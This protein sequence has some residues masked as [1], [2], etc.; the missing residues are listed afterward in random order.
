MASRCCSNCNRWLSKDCYSKTQWT[1]GAGISR[2]RGCLN[3]G[4]TLDPTR[5]ARQNNS[6]KAAFTSEALTYPFAQG[7]FRWV[8]RGR[9][10]EGTRAGEECVCKWFKTG[11]VVESHFFDTDIATV[12]EAVRLITKWNARGVVNKMVQVNR[13]EVWTFDQY[14]GAQWAGK[15]VLQEPFIQNYQK[16]NSNT[17]WSDDTLPWPRVMQALSHFS[18]HV[19]NGESVLC[20]LQGG[21]YSDGVVLTDPVVM[22]TSRRFGPTDLGAA[23]ISSFFAHHTCNEYC[24]SEWRK[25]RN[26]TPYYTATAGT[27]MEQV[28]THHSRPRMTLNYLGSIQER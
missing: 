25:P 28:P 16:F 18:Y 26:Q 7:A 2:C 10:T 8:A 4:G 14:S 13:P 6:S 27:T 17:G 3:N 11:G 1:K 15:K 24:R 21:F 22:S 9:Y 23:G 20:D 19:S 12:E 5:T